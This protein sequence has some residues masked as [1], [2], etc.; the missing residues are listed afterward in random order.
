MT[1]MPPVQVAMAQAATELTD[2]PAYAWRTWIVY[3]LRCL[4]K[5]SRPDEYRQALQALQAEIAA[6]LLVGRW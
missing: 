4:E 6:R 2:M 1:E 3:M 5:G